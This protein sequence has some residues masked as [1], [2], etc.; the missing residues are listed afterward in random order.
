MERKN[1]S[2]IPTNNR[3]TRHLTLLQKTEIHRTLDLTVL[4]VVPLMNQKTCLSL[5]LAIALLL[6]S[7]PVYAPYTPTVGSYI[8]QLE[9]FR[10]N[11][12][13]LKVLVD[14]NQWSIPDYAAAVH[15]S[16]QGWILSIWSY[17]QTGYKTLRSI[18]Y[19]FYL[20][21]VNSTTDYDVLVTFTSNEI[22]PNVV[23]LTTSR[24]NPATHEPIPPIT[25]NITTYSKTANH[26]FVR[27]IA[28]HEFGHALGLG[29]ASS[30]T[31]T[32][33]PEL[34]YPQSTV[35]KVVYPSTL[36]LYGLT[37][38]YQGSFGQPVQLPASIPYQIV[39]PTGVQPVQ[40]PDYTRLF[41]LAALFSLLFL[42]L[43]SSIAF[44]RRRTEKE[45]ISVYGIPEEAGGDEGIHL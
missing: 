26:L 23:G 18:S 21:N 5:A 29:H 42:G 30:Q 37:V 28:M 9:A 7:T 34:M 16:L 44:T 35:N 39:W 14:M 10:W 17:N 33:G 25:I 6:S 8:I 45:E 22:S 27:N 32:D 11:S 2:Q 15:E 36:D 20:S 4:Q 13:P 1:L 38:L 31:T 24:W 41:I 12:F 19:A 3:Y 40:E 43:A